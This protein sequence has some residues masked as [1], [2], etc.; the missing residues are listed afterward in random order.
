MCPCTRFPEM[1]VLPVFGMHFV[2]VIADEPLESSDIFDMTKAY[3]W[4]V[5][6]KEVRVVKGTCPECLTLQDAFVRARDVT[7]AHSRTTF[8]HFIYRLIAPSWKL[9]S[10][11]SPS[12]IETLLLEWMNC[13]ECD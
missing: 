4:A 12:R 1:L 3:W 11:Y 6:V 5:A 2:L 13:I 10:T 7:V 8:I 9:Q